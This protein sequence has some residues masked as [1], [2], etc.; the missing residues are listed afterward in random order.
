MMTRH[1]RSVTVSSAI[2]SQ[3]PVN[4]KV[5]MKLH[6]RF[7][8]TLNFI[9][10]NRIIAIQ[11]PSSKLVPFGIRCNTITQF[12][13]LS[14]ANYPLFLSRNGIKSANFD[15]KFLNPDLFSLQLN[16]NSSMTN[17]HLKY[18]QDK[19]IDNSELWRD[20]GS[21]Y[22]FTFP[23]YSWVFESSKNIE[24][25][26]LDLSKFKSILEILNSKEIS[27]DFLKHLLGWGAGSTPAGDDFI[28]GLLAGILATQPTLLTKHN[29]FQTTLTT[30]LSQKL[31][32][33][34]SQEFLSY[35]ILSH[36]SESILDFLS[37]F[38]DHTLIT[39]QLLS[40]ILIGST[41]GIDFLWGFI[42]TV[43]KVLKI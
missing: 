29:S 37:Q 10:N 21:Q 6:S 25:N 1:N 40:N 38:I 12:Q 27:Y 35:A 30:L 26:S 39:K 32:P 20:K 24:N 2:W 14:S 5:K 28:V 7:D 11:S 42:W 3:I 22:D 17:L 23:L 43:E 19:L 36:F 31:T 16:L 9:A 41:S 15:V 33:M 8:S 18:L 4:R 13:S 34:I